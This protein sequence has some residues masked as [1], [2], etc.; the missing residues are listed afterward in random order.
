MIATPILTESQMKAS[1]SRIFNTALLVIGV[2]LSSLFLAYLTFYLV[3][4]LNIYELIRFSDDENFDREL[5]SRI[6][7]LWLLFP[8]SILFLKNERAKSY[9]ISQRRHLVMFALFWLGAF[10]AVADPMHSMRSEGNWIRYWT[11]GVLIS[12]GIVA[13]WNSFSRKHLLLDRLFGAAF[14]LLLIAAAGDELFQFHESTADSVGRFLPAGSVV[15]G[16]DAPTLAVGVV[17]FVGLCAC[18]LV[19]RIVPWTRHFFL[20]P[21]YRRTLFLLFIGVTI[22]LTAMM[23]DTFDWYLESMIEPIRSTFMGW[24]GLGEVPHWIGKQNLAQAANS[25]EELLEYMAA[26]S[27]FMAIATA[28][29]IK[30]LGG[31]MT[32]SR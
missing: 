9:F 13:I 4:Q 15:S 18:L 22:F 30:A 12:A 25:L 17:G 10:F 5:F 8:V 23:L 1:K 31:N 28:F 32:D 11:A 16:Q 20:D 27:F 26:I 7:V 21:R 6:F 14:G 24:S 3:E 29:S 2:V 19:G